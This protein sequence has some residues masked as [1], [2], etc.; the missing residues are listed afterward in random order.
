MADSQY[1]LNNSYD[2][3]DTL[4]TLN[5]ANN[6][7]M[8]SL[9]ISSLYTNIP[10]AETIDL[11]LDKLYVNNTSIYNGISRVNFRK[12]LELSL[13]DTYFKFN[14]KIYKQKEGLAMGASPSPIIA[15]IF[16][17]HF[18]THCLAECP[19]NFKPQFYRRYLDDTFLIFRNEDQ[20]KLFL[21]L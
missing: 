19:V 21:I 12:L 13:N 9:D 14:G 20:A 6:S 1:N 16:L 10:V 5:G 4:R 2:F 17:N 8:C 11:I 3:A 18:E 7:F 15:N